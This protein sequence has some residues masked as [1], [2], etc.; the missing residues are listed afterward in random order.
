MCMRFV[1]EFNSLG[2]CNIYYMCAQDARVAEPPSLHQRA[3]TQVS[4]NIIGSLDYDD[5]CSEHSPARW[6]ALML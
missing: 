2:E 6:R 3:L 1:P 4:Y 5:K